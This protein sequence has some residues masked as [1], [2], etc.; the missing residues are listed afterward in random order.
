MSIV[1]HPQ[2]ARVKDA[3]FSCVRESE[4]GRVCIGEPTRRQA[5]GRVIVENF[6]T[7]CVSRLIR[8]LPRD[9]R[10]FCRAPANGVD[11]VT[12][13]KVEVYY[14]LETAVWRRRGVILFF[15]WVVAPV[16]GSFLYLFY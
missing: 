3:I 2:T 8:A 12:L 14:P 10:V 4:R 15:V 11:R 5:E 9:C 16:L 7:L 1:A 6:D 13:S